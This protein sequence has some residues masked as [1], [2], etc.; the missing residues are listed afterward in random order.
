MLYRRSLPRTWVW[1]GVTTVALLGALAIYLVSPLNGNIRYEAGVKQA[2]TS[3]AAGTFSH[4]P[5]AFRMLM[6]GVFRLAHA[7]SVGTAS[8]E[9][10]VRL[11]AAAMAVGSGVLLWRGLLKYGVRQPGLHAIVVVG[12]I[13]L[14]S[15]INTGEPDWMAT[16]LA[17]AGTGLALMGRR[18]PWLWALLAAA[19]F[20]GAAGMKVITL[21]TALLGLGVVALLDRRQLLRVLIGTVVVGSLYVLITVVWV[22]WEVQWLLDI[23]TV[24][25]D[26]WAALPD[27][28]PF[29]AEL[30]GPPTSSCAAARDA[31]ARRAAG[32]AADGA[33]PGPEYGHGGHSGAVLRL[34]Q[35]PDGGGRL[36]RGVPR[37]PVS[38]VDDS[39]RRGDGRRA[40]GRGA[41]D[42][43]QRLAGQ[44]PTAVGRSD[45]RGGR[46]GP[47][48]GPRRPRPAASRR[49][50]QSLLAA[51][52]TLALL[53]PSSTPWA[54]QLLRP[55]NPNG[56]R[57]LSRL[58]ARTKHEAT[59]RQVRQ[60]VGG[61]DVPVTYLT[62]GE[63]T[64][65]IGNP[66]T[67]R[68]PSPL[69][70]QRTAY[71]RRQV[72]TPS[73]QENL[74]C[75][76][77][78]GSRWLIWDPSWFSLKRTPAGVQ[79]IIAHEWDCSAPIEVGEL[80]LCPRRR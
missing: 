67:C 73:Y 52:A 4:R 56:Q 65:F 74:D 45:D 40:C 57:P 49:P 47:D 3:S 20:V 31:G 53:L 28:I 34:S 77:A 27:A 60:A 35:R 6:D 15:P 8:F 46:G 54:A 72:G 18:R 69:F 12:A 44:P 55:E 30:G 63:W 62:F 19:L 14:I 5:L 24:Q 39:R 70:L 22:P 79:A 66:T 51:L 32:T 78:S 71:T 23:R 29:L 41:D 2:G 37:P 48:L 21:P 16:V 25:K 64:Y 68:Y 42:R 76:S 33:G 36:G 11:L 50:G 43:E 7:L 13:L 59:A 75:L 9:L 38:D 26:A 17:T 1:V 61:P 10:A 58:E 80:R